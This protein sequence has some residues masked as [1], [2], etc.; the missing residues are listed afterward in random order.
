MIES[1]QQQ[2]ALASETAAKEY[3][4]VVVAVATLRGEVETEMQALQQ[5]LEA[6]KTAV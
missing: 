5:Q 3:R 4:D 1:L 2:L 6:S